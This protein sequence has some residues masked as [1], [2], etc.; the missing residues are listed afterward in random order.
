MSNEAKNIIQKKIDEGEFKGQEIWINQ[1]DI[2]WTFQN[3]EETIYIT[4]GYYR[5][6]MVFFKSY[7]TDFD[8][9]LID[10]LIDIKIQIGY[11]CF[12]IAL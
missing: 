6:G 12:A 8:P 5:E 11:K 3:E 2:F 1:N 7:K 9:C 4:E 10:F